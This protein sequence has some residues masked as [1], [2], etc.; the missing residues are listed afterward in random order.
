MHILPTP[1]AAV[2]HIGTAVEG[3]QSGLGS[4]VGR[5]DQRWGPVP[6]MRP[7]E[8][9]V[10]HGEA[11]GFEFPVAFRLETFSL[12]LATTDGGDGPTSQGFAGRRALV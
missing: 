2:G 6:E 7:S 8:G 1:K 4:L 12:E 11:R 5:S 9:P 10:R 3:E